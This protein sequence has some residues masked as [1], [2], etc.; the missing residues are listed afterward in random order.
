MI[1]KSGGSIKR[2]YND[3]WPKKGDAYVASWWT[4]PDELSDNQYIGLHTTQFWFRLK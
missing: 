2:I 4:V 3:D 1:A